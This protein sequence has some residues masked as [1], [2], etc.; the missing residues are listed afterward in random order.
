MR[1]RFQPLP[2]ANPVPL[3]LPA[4]RT[5][6]VGA[7][8]GLTA[9]LRIAISG[10][11]VAEATQRSFRMLWP[12]TPDCAAAFHS[13]FLNPWNMVAM[14]QEGVAEVRCLPRFH[15]A[16][17]PMLLA[18]SEPNIARRFM[19]WHDFPA[20]SSLLVRCRTLMNEL[21]PVPLVIEKVDRFRLAHHRPEMIGV[22]LRRGDYVDLRP[23]K[24]H[25]TDKAIEA[26]DAFLDQY[27]DAGILLCTDEVVTSESR[28]GDVRRRFTARYGDRLVQTAPATYDRSDPAAIEDALVDLWLLRSMTAFV[29]SEYSGFS[30]LAFFGRTVPYRMVGDG[31]PA[32]KRLAW[33]SRLRFFNPFIRRLGRREFGVDHPLPFLI[34]HYS[35]K[36][37]G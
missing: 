1:G 12:M 21:Q 8:A 15:E 10:L 30:E 13:L 28:D 6:T 37:L 22:H 26:T 24:T 7:V 3:D 23:D 29:G 17:L 25:N 2:M 14:G 32:W 27:P 16:E 9:R 33:L 5:L 36:W 20:E 34:E 19:S 35:R 11:A 31:S 4:D 18:S